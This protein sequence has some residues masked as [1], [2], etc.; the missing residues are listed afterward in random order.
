MSAPRLGPGDF[1]RYFHAVH[2]DEPFPWQERLA[3]LVFEKGWPAALDVP[4]G[5]GKTAALD[6]GV[7]HLA[8]EA[9]RGPE[10]RAPVRI[11]FVVDRRLVVD[12]A[13][14]RAEVIAEALDAATDGVLV[15]VR[16]RLRLLA[17]TASP[18]LTVAKLRG[19]IP[20]EPDWVHTPCQPTVVVSTVDQVGSRFF[21]R[22]YG[23]SDSMKPVHAGLL[24]VDALYLLDEA[25]LS[26]PF[27]QSLRDARQYQE[28]GPWSD[29]SAGA[30]F[31]IAA[32]SATQTEEAPALVKG[33]DRKHPV[34]GRRLSARKDV[35]LVS[36][37]ENPGSKEW[38]RECAGRAWSLS[39]LGGGAATA[40][41]VVVNRVASARAVFEALHERLGDEPAGDVALLI[42]PSRQ[43]GRDARLGEL[44]PRMK[45][46]RNQE[47]AT[48]PLFVVATQCIEAGADLDFDAMVTEIAPLDCVRQR[49]GRLNRMGRPGQATGLVLASSSQVHVRAEPD[50]IYGD[51]LAATWAL[52]A[53]KAET[54][55]KGKAKS[56]WLDFGITACGAWLPTK[57]KLEPYLAPRAEAPVML[58]AFVQQWSQ[59]SPVPLGDPDVALFL[60]GPA[61]R[62]G[63]VQVVWRADLDEAE[64]ELW[65]D[66]VAIC[67]PS[68]LE[69]IGLPFY[70]VRAW[71]QAQRAPE[72]ADVELGAAPDA[73]PSGRIARRALRWRG[74]DDDR[75]QAILPRE[76]MPDDVLVVPAA[77]GGCD[78][79]GWAPA[80]DERVPDLGTQASR[81]QRGV[82]VLRLTRPIV[83]EAWEREGCEP[84]EAQVRA[85][86]LVGA[87]AEIADASAREVRQAFATH[88]DVPA[89]W[90]KLL[91]L[92]GDRLE[93]Y[94]YAERSPRI[95]NPLAFVWPR[96]GRDAPTSAATEGDAGS[97]SSR[98]V[99]LAPHTGG[100]RDL[101]REFAE[102]LGLTGDLVASIALAGLLH[103]AGKA[104]PEFKRW[105]YGGD[106]LAAFSGDDLAKSG[107]SLG[108]RERSRAGLPVGARHELASLSLA[109]A[110]P[111]VREVNDPDLVLWLIGTHHGHGRPFFP[112]LTWPLP[113]SAFEAA[114]ADGTAQSAPAPSLAA[115]TA[116]WCELHARLTKRYGPWGLARLEAVLRLAD[117][118]RSA[119][120]E[121][122]KCDDR[123]HT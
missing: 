1:A 101:A 32:L 16:E 30:P 92:K 45:A 17:G 23:V 75:T 86:R 40:T 47:A 103:D 3:R 80:S 18:P 9:T 27:V 109:E 123:E 73:S 74:A 99:R 72:L 34:L 87:L 43:L 6:V 26:H 36:T 41:A 71:L 49:F 83:A 104:H 106:E 117:H 76:V 122:G 111:A 97:R 8:L 66:H 63:D 110:H 69:S 91:Q 65:K 37:A 39:K 81:K 95:G 31:A 116:G 33:D 108:R 21:F 54:R 121:E 38:V 60:H 42:G 96:T 53:E 57:D 56:A 115:F 44:L 112:P 105:L 102:R 67:P 46:R 15:R 10:R 20:H 28:A 119:L 50:P 35:E 25:H 120:E 85:R 24:G 79:W 22:G 14:R 84:A 68:A 98:P 51:R 59:T 82:E 64:H 88:D 78:E 52:L 58:P 62:P 118:R 55:G 13:H 94:D 2:G 90:K 4:T 114:L 12:E 29:D 77:Y 93:R 107:R 61:S 7:F 113:G 19:G 100:V 70:A 11:V 89:S 48:R 5:A